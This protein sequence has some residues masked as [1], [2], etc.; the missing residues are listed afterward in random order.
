MLPRL[1]RNRDYAEIHG[2]GR[3]LLA[4]DGHVFS[5]DGALVDEPAAEVAAEGGREADPN[6][7][8][9]PVESVEQP[10]DLTLTASGE[11]TRVDKDDMRLAANK[12]LKAQ[13][14]AFGEPWQGVTHARKFILGHE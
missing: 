6:Y 3:V 10:P 13:M 2:G 5:K 8:A 9:A 11:A 12:A 7:V 1:D 4:Q 14:E